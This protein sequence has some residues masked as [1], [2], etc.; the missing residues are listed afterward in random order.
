M[1]LVVLVA[2]VLFVTLT[3]MQPEYDAYGWLV[4]GRQALHWNL[5]TN[6]APSWKPLTFLFTFPYALSGRDQPW[7]W[8]VTAVAGAF[9][10]SV[11]AARLAYRLSGPAPG[12]RHAPV[13]AAAFAGVGVLGIVGYWPLVLIASSDPM[14]AAL[15][16]AAI[17]CHLSRRP[18][19]AFGLL[20]LAALARPE[21]WPFVAVYAAWLWR[22]VPG[23]RVSTVLGMLAIAALWFGISAL[24]AK[25]WLRAGEV[26]LNTASTLRHDP[27][28]GTISRFGGLYELPMWLAAA[29]GVALAVVR[30][31]RVVL[32]LAGAALV[33]V[34]IEAGFAVHGWPAQPRYMIEP[35]A[36]FVVIAGSAVGRLLAAGPGVS[37]PLRW[38]GAAMVVILLA[39]LVPTAR[40]RFSVLRAEINQRRRAGIEIHRLAGVIASDGGARAILAC[41]TAVSVVGFQSTLAWYLGLNVGFVGHKPGQAIHRHYPIVLFKPFD[42]G[43]KVLPIHIR[44]RQRARCDRL[45]T[46][47][48]TG[49]DPP[50]AKR[51]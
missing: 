49:P 41:G 2:S 7:L 34:A 9:S 29:A 19:L 8:M 16:L 45:R 37:Q 17:D 18:R 51:A 21:A 40:D 5:N 35:A 4:W 24:T 38:V 22:A 14:V 31:D 44:R 43:W 42:L 48:A 27:I 15:C 36:V 11:F 23:V 10:A 50:R 39:A 47:T 26:A 3:R 32:T 20:V 12:R 33:W 13:L 28:G 6:G 1:A 46:M 30:R 25:T